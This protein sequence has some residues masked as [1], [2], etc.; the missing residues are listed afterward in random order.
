MSR[1]AREAAFPAGWRAAGGG[2][3][4]LVLAWAAIELALHLGWEVAQLP[5]YTIAGDPDRIYVVRAVLHCTAGD[6]LIALTA[7]AVAAAALRETRWPLGRHWHG[8][9]LAT[10]GAL[11]YT[12]YS[13][14][15]NVQVQ[16]NWAYREAMP[17]LFGLGLAP[18]AQWLLLPAAGVWLLRRM[19]FAGVRR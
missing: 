3:P 19:W 9:A 2:V 18:L 1:A 13:E 7:Y 16:G 6:V 17:R 5:L 11:A 14:W 10:V 8:I 4:A 12:V 15:N